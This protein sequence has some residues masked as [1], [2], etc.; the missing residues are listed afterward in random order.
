MFQKLLLISIFFFINTTNKNSD[1]E[2]DIQNALKLLRE[3]KTE[4]KQLDPHIR[5]EALSIVFPEVMRYN[6]FKDFF[7][8]KSLELVYV[9]YGKEKADFSIGYFQ[10]KP[11]F[12]EKLEKKL[13]IN[14]SLSIDFKDILIFSSTDSVEIRKE[15]IKRLKDFKV[16]LRYALAYR[17][18]C[19]GI[20]SNVKFT[21]IE[22]KI[23]FYATAYN[24]GFDK[25]VTTI[26]QWV[27]KKA[28]PYGEKYKG[29]QLAFSDLSIDFYT[30]YSLEF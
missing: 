7:E 30:K 27:T 2:K 8:T 17:M 23:R 28:F 14:P 3:K 6:I 26:K 25:D 21:N 15:R 13:S 1:F 16:Q 10:M 12:V 5:T 20:F 4:I 9:N 11:S 24:T 22:E 19:N 18:L 29:N